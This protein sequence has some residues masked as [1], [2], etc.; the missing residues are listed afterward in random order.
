[1]TRLFI[2]FSLF[3]IASNSFSQ[4]VPSN[5]VAD[6]KV[7]YY[8]LQHVNVYV[9]STEL[10]ENATVLIKGDKI[11]KI[12]KLINLPNGCVEI[13]MEGQTIIPS[14]IE[15]YANIALPKPTSSGGFR[16]QIESA[17]QGAYYWNESIHPELDAATLF[18]I[19]SK[20]NENFIS[21]GFGFA[22]THVQ[23][24]IVRGSGALIS[25]GN[26]NVNKQLISSHAGNFYSFS[27]GISS[28]SY[29]SSQ[30]GAIALLRQSLYDLSYYQS[31]KLNQE[32]SISLDSWAKHLHGPSF[33]KV[34]EKWEILRANKI[35]KEFGLDFIYIASGNEYANVNELKKILPKLIVP[36]NFPLAYDVQDPYLARQIPLSDLKHWELAPYNPKFL[37]DNGLT[38]ALTSSGIESPKTFWKNIRKQVEVGLSVQQILEALTEIPAKMIGQE[39]LIGSLQDGKLASFSVFDGNPFLAEV[40]LLESWQLGERRIL[41]TPQKNN[42]LGDFTLML[43]GKKYELQVTGSKEKPSGKVYYTQEK[44]VKKKTVVD[45]ISSDVT[46][47][48]NQADIS[49]AFNFPTEN[50]SGG[51]QLHGKIKRKGEIIE[52]DA[53]LPDGNWSEW[54]AIKKQK[55][56]N[57]I[58][59]EKTNVK[60][61][62]MEP[63]SWL[64]NLAFGRNTELV[65]QPLVIKNTTLWTNEA[66]GIM[67]NATVVCFD[68]KIIIVSKNNVVIPPN[69]IIIDGKGMHLTSGII[70]EH[71]HIAISKGVNEGGQTVTAEVSIADVVNPDDINIY[72]QLAGGVTA[73]Q[74]LHGSANTIGGQSAL[75]KLKWGSSPDEMIIP[76]APKFIKCALG[77]NVKQSNWGDYSTV[78][79][80]QTRMG[81]EQVFYDGF[82]RAEA[83]KKEWNTFLLSKKTDNS[84]TPRKD[85][86]LEVLCEI[87]SGERKITCHSYVQSEINMLM[88]V[89][90]SMG[91]TVNTFTHILEGYK[92]A[93]KMKEHG[94]GASTFSD[95]WAYKF[96]VNDAIPYNASLMN[97]QG[98]VV[99]INSDD[100]E[101]GRRLN[102]EAAKSV[103]YGGMS[104]I[105]AWKMVTLNPSK[106]LHLDDRMGSIRVGKDADLVL[107]S[108][109][110][111]SIN[112][113]VQM[114]VIDGK[115]LFSLEEDK[116]SQSRNKVERARL[117]SLMLSQNKSNGDT[118]K[119]KLKRNKHFHCNTIGEEGSELENSH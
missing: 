39:A 104:E 63:K 92:L 17:K 22:V 84:I 15:L 111:L 7:V 112:A 9:S 116:L 114:T 30:M 4:L 49:M 14:F 73:A 1:M 68:G 44:I 105:D 101:M 54:A 59:E 16:P 13:D 27:K 81:V 20:A 12:G 110:P 45:T 32:K 66:E 80:P 62:V 6:S 65:D 74:L 58:D 61:T 93:D 57:K 2:L 38:V 87:L 119:F 10:V 53:L 26:E 109:N 83:Y 33:F 72:R 8:A 42:L 98:I 79:F 50:K 29:P 19:D 100:A 28:Q 71:S 108:D 77:E 56:S 24:G 60:E 48:I 52:G 43:K 103:K 36:M 31:N 107:W 64:P 69:A 102:Q 96:E 118:Q 23:D 34:D 85:L 76:N 113:I 18:Q 86:E 40:T 41:T 70:D 55:N 82:V 88:K 46:I 47:T 89:A 94:V 106:L 117:T 115:I 35:S 37:I 90:D 25:L 99:A 91:F 11:E 21:M 5:G 95:W 97:Q 51:Y 3:L 75:I 78:R 67:E